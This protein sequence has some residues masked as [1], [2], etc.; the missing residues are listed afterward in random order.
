MKICAQCSSVLP[1]G[2]IQCPQCQSVLF[3]E[4]PIPESSATSTDNVS[5]SAHSWGFAFSIPMALI[6]LSI[7]SVS[8]A[9]NEVFLGVAGILFLLALPWS[10]IALA[11]YLYAVPMNSG[12]FPGMEGYYWRTVLAYSAPIIAIL[13]AHYNGF[14]LG[15]AKSRNVEFKRDA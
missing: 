10:F 6:F 7:S 1:D 5:A 2:K 15:R 13:G 9:M 4:M 8:A 11:I 14:L 3:E 12:L